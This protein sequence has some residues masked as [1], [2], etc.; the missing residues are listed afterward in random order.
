MVDCN[1]QLEG[2]KNHLRDRSLGVPVGYY[3][4]SYKDLSI[5]GCTICWIRI[6]NHN[7]MSTSVYFFLVLES[8]D[9]A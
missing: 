9:A 4:A 3:L 1:C 8:L 2:I 5:V 6:L 7:E